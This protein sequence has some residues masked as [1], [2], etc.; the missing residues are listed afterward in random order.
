MEEMTN[1]FKILVGKPEGKKLLGNLGVDG[2]II[3]KCLREIG[4]KSTDWIHLA[5]N[6][7]QW[8]VREHGSEPSDSMKD[9]EYIG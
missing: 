7:D 5:Q 9:G 1:A 4:W 8:R 2:K 3:L 6:R